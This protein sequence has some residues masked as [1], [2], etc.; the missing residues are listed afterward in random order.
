MKRSKVYA[1][2]AAGVVAAMV[3]GS[4]G[5]AV[6]A[7]AS[8]QPTS[9]VAATGL[10][11]GRT[12]R[13]AGAGMVDILA[14]LTGLSTTEIRAERAAGKSV[15]DIA[16]AEGVD[17]DAM[18]AE[19]LDA[20]TAMLDARIKDGSM[21]QAEADATLALMKE[22]LVER[23]TTTDTGRPSWAGAGQ[24]AGACGGDQGVGAGG[25]GRGAGAGCDSCTVV[26]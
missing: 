4:V 12:I 3:L 15:A 10:Q 14:G 2:A 8:A 20:R 5:Y 13:D 11:L 26:Q 21:T 7:P 25:R 23:V 22:R 1:L 16:K 9:P 19:A 24:G 17:P 18:V 6:A